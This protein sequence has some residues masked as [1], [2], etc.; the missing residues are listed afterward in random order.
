MSKVKLL[1]GEQMGINDN[2]RDDF[3]IGNGRL[4]EG[5]TYRRGARRKT[6]GTLSLVLFV[7]FLLCVVIVGIVFVVR[8]FIKPEPIIDSSRDEVVQT[9]AEKKN[10]EKPQ[11][12]MMVVDDLFIEH[13]N[14]LKKLD[15]GAN[16]G[17]EDICGVIYSYEDD[18]DRDGE[19]E[20]LVVGLTSGKY[21]NLEFFEKENEQVKRKGMYLF[22]GEID[23]SD[24]NIFNV[25]SYICLE[26][27]NDDEVVSR[28]LKYEKDL[29][30]AF[31]ND[32]ADML[33][34]LSLSGSESNLD[35][36]RSTAVCSFKVED[37]VLSF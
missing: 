12:D 4:R 17:D 21:L 15:A 6:R 3:S 31:D 25:D 9:I 20:L 28:F 22:D 7:V 2:D 19:T 27:I 37:M 1:R 24:F 13:L 16:I 10:E 33:E 23:N 29:K 26:C 36:I 5:A 34:T 30:L 8:I 32:D 11:T 14:S 35:H 18:F